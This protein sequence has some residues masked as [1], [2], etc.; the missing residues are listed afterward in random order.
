MAP[1]TLSM[2]GPTL[3]KLHGKILRS[4]AKQQEQSGDKVSAGAQQNKVKRVFQG[5]VHGGVEVFHDAE[6]D[7]DAIDALDKQEVAA[8]G[9]VTETERQLMTEIFD[10]DA[11]ERALDA[12]TNPEVTTANEGGV[13][14]NESGWTVDDILLAAN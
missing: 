11:Y 6:D 13:T 10:F 14:S 12:F 7:V 8:A 2:T 5:E 9:P 1:G 3:A 4:I